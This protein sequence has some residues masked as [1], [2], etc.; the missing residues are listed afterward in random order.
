MK[1]RVELD[2]SISAIVK[3]LAVV[4]ALY[5]LV[6]IADVI[7]LLF[8]VLVVA[9]AVAPIV[10]KWSQKMPRS[11]AA[12]L[13]FI[14][15][16]AAFVAVFV[17]LIPPVM[18][19][20]R[21]LSVNL[22]IYFSRSSA[23]Q[24]GLSA[25]ILDRLK[26]ELPAQLQAISQK[27]PTLV[28]NFFGGFYQVFVAAFL[29]FYFILEEKSIKKFFISFVPVDKKD[30]VKDVFSKI[31]DKMGDWLRGQL[32]L[33]LTIG[34]IDTIILYFLGVPYF[35]AL[36]LWAGL[37]E[38]IPYLGPVLGAVPAVFLALSLGSPVTALL[39]VIFYTAVQQLEANFLV[40]KIMQ[41]AVGL[42]PVAV[43]L[44]LTV[45]G[46]LFGIS[47]VILAVPAAAAI[48]V[49]WQDW[50]SIQATFKAF[51]RDG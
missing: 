21:Q 13:I 40:P 22:P 2:I 45:G 16:V 12:L 6:K 15:V 46:K 30:K 47:G 34:I 50:P 35:L 7:V 4:L 37:T 5:T 19:Q 33:M 28:I 29:T 8:V 11:I 38:I 17:L 31:G 43:I 1:D 32:L 18:E 48:A 24:G 27:V 51:R 10:D 39:V 14:L 23:D 49:I 42:S 20:V 9:A 26:S 41:R 3:I 36:G 44:A 25:S